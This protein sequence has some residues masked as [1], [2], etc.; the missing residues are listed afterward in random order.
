VR[1][2]RTTQRGFGYVGLLILVL[3]MTSSM[4]LVGPTWQVAAQREKERELLFVG[5]EY[6]R[7]I[8]AYARDGGGERG[9][10][11]GQLEDL[12]K[13][14][15]VPATRRYLRKIYPDPMTNSQEWGLVRRPDG[16]I[17][18]L[19]SRSE[20]APLKRSGFRGADRDFEGKEKYSDWVF[21]SRLPPP[22]QQLPDQGPGSQPPGGQPPG[23]QPPGSQPPGSQLPFGGTQPAAGP[24]PAPTNPPAVFGR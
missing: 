5:N 9:G 22:G 7:A 10:Y 4:A 16:G 21:G 2:P 13:D 3:L 18:G 19:Y 20:L 6:R 11:P 14:P 15:R 12:L 17:I 8:A 24:A 23:S 1:G